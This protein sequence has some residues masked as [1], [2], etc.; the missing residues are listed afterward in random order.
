MTVFGSLF[1]IA[2][3]ALLA[4]RLRS[5][6]TFIGIVFGVTS[7]MTIISALEG[8]M[9]VIEQQ[10]NSLG[11][12]TFMVSKMLMVTSDE[13]FREKRKHKPILLDAVDLVEE[14]CTL[15]EKVSPRSIT[16]RN[17]KYGTETL[18][19]I[20][21]MGGTA[22]FIDIVD[23][24]VSQGRFHSSED[25]LYKHQVVFIGDDLRERFFEG[26][27]PLGKEIK[28]GAKRYTVIGVNKKRGAMFGESQ[29]DFA[30]IPLSTFI[31]QFGQRRRGSN[32]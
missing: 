16:F 11:P 26:V 5:S 22:S 24:E 20:P 3:G 9:G 32:G 18:R 21:I 31:G 8:M 2:F 19:R 28:I 10:I 30:V 1:R 23:M 27:D 13:M 12:S 17:V 15:C 7:V 4:N 6:L 29:D 14:S 25:D